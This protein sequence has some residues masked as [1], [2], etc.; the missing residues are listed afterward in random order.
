MLENIKKNLNKR[1]V[2]YI[3]SRQ[4][5]GDEVSIAWLV[6][7][8]DRLNEILNIGTNPKGGESSDWTAQEGNARPKCL[9]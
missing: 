9:F 7:E 1:M 6:M 5:T 2:G 3:D 4:P 8:V